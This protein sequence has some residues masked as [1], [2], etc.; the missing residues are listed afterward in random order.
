MK[1]IYGGKIEVHQQGTDLVHVITTEGEGDDARSTIV[2]LA[3]A[4]ARK[5]ARKLLAA[6]AAIDPPAIAPTHYAGE[7]DAKTLAPIV[8]AA[9]AVEALPDVDP[10]EPAAGCC[11]GGC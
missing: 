3:P 10:A 4:Q 9:I 6:A 5:L 11:G 7:M 8:A 1:D 2:S